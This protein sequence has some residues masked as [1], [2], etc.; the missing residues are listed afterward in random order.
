[1]RIAIVTDVHGNR[2]AFDAVLRDLRDASLDLVLHGGD[3][4]HG[5]S[6]PIEIVD[7]IR[8]LGWP[9]VCGNTDEMLFDPQSLEDFAGNR[10][11]MPELFAAI[12]EMAAWTREALGEE[13]LAWL[14]GL[15]R[16][17]VWPPVAL[18]HASPDSTWRSPAHNAP[19]AELE[20]VY[21][22]LRQP[23]AVY[24]HIHHPFARNLEGLTVVNAGSISLSYDGDPRAS[25]L[26][27]DDG[28]PTLRRVEY[29]V[30]REIKAIRAIGIPHA[31]WV[32]R[33]LRSAS[34]QML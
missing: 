5:G 10:P 14:S 16:T 21:S 7:Q 12:R 4:P 18:V 15:P 32:A 8:D 1:M 2:F 22:P 29:D 20:A 23:I 25:Y 9:G 33:C 31:D 17:Q 28:K 27:I 19:D 30:E 26:L 13:R 3:L 24:G 34:P 11:R 6:A